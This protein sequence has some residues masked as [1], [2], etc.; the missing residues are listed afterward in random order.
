MKD[1]DIESVGSFE[2]IV[3]HQVVQGKLGGWVVGKTGRARETLQLLKEMRRIFHITH[4]LGDS[5]AGSSHM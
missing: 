1:G 4:S 3:D 5:R 2:I